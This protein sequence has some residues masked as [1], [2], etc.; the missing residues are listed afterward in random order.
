MILLKNGAEYSGRS[1]EKATEE[2]TSESSTRDEPW[3]V[4]EIGGHAERRKETAGG[5]KA[6]IG[7]VVR[8]LRHD[9]Y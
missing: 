7:K 3:R 9:Y 4:C 8:P 6:R 1:L 2:A 5:N